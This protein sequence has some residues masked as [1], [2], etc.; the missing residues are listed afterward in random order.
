[1]GF[2]GLAVWGFGGFGGLGVW[3]FGCG[4]QCSGVDML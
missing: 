3:G 1:M 2:G 4:A